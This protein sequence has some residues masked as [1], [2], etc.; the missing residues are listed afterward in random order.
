M[1]ESSESLEN[2]RQMEELVEQLIPRADRPYD[3]PFNMV[4][5]IAFKPMLKIY[6]SIGTGFFLTK[7][8]I[9]TPE[10]SKGISRLILLIL[11]PSLIFNNIV[12]QIKDTDAR[13]LGVIV[14]SGFIYYVIGLGWGFIIRGLTP[15][16]RAWFGGLLLCCMINNCSDLPLA[17]IQTIGDSPLLPAE[18]AS[19]GVSYCVLFT[20]VFTIFTFNLGGT[21]LIQWDAA[22]V[23][24]KR[25][26]PTVPFVSWQSAKA[27]FKIEQN[28]FS[29]SSEYCSETVQKRPSISSSRFG[30]KQRGDPEARDDSVPS[31]DHEN[32]VLYNGANHLSSLTQTATE[33]SPAREQSG[34]PWG[35]TDVRY[36][37]AA[38]SAMDNEDF[39]DA[40][41]TFTVASEGMVAFE[42]M[43]R[44]TSRSSDPNDN[45]TAAEQNCD[46]A[47]EE[48]LSAILCKKEQVKQPTSPL[49]RFKRRWA[50]FKSKNGVT[51][52]ICNF[53][54]DLFLPQMLALLSSLFVAMMPWVRRVFVTGQDIKGFHDAPDQMPPLSFIMEFLS[55]FAG[56]QVPLGLMLLGG[57]IASLKFGKFVPGF[58]MTLAMIVVFKLVILPIIG[59]AWIHRLRTAQWI[60]K[61]DPTIPIVLAVTSGTPSATV[62]IFLTLAWVDPTKESVEL[63]CLALALM[64][65]Y[66]LLPITMTFLMIYVVMYFV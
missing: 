52:Y 12:S 50:A 35:S 41:S 30:G 10:I 22:R 42:S 45:N 9:L 24:P 36:A 65:Q 33:D 26:E 49:Q 64:F 21:R 27:L 20:I 14:F 38:E 15:I 29:L 18:V 28:R 1:L 46:L 40:R 47:N 63:N 6:L 13:L 17:Y 11:L 48:S 8:G 55:F 37:R 25:E 44:R 43:A 59:C 58:W 31:S 53:C 56:A 32:Y 2:L 7:M 51:K 39:I 23:D 60:D 5:W 34:Q 62:Q 54:E 16:P 66:A 57:T 61:N 19:K 4:V 3:I